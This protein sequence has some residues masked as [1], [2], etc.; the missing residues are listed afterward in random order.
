MDG[1]ALLLVSLSLLAVAVAYSSVG[2][3]GASGY[4][5]VLTLAG[6]AS[7]E[8][9]P[10]ALAL[11]LVVGGV[12]LARFAGAGHVAWRGVAPLVL[13]SAPM[14][15]LGA[16]LRLPEGVHDLALST[17]L[18][19]SALALFRTASLAPTS[20]A[21]VPVA[22]VPWLAGLPVGAAIGLLSGITGTGGAIFLTPI[23]LVMGW[24]ATRDAS[25]LSVAFVWANSLLG[26][27]GLAQV[28]FTLPGTF[29]WWL[30]A[31]LIGAMVGTQLG[32]KVLPVPTLRRVLGCVLLVASAKLAFL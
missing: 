11:N 9:R 1:A 22:R 27:I 4:I 26:L 14:A 20:D 21:R 15:W 32:L 10:T 29:P 18:A 8:I 31:V 3:A 16:R 25:G 2:H 23:L 24:A 12:G 5:A 19:I 17:V 13:T 6:I 30:L 7:P 28:G